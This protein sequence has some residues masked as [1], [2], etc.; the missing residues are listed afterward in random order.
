[1]D[2][3]ASLP[4]W[5]LTMQAGFLLFIYGLHVRKVERSSMQ[6]VKEGELLVA[7]HCSPG[8]AAGVMRRSTLSSTLSGKLQKKSMPVS[9]S[10]SSMVMANS[11]KR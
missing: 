11:L 3:Q 10:N 6:R 2:I 7:P 1:M 5:F 9:S 8:H 4:V